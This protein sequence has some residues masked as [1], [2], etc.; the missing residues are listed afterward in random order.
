MHNIFCQN[1]QIFPLYKRRIDILC[2]EG[3]NTFWSIA[4]LNKSHTC[5]PD[6]LEIINFTVPLF[7]R[8]YAHEH[9]FSVSSIHETTLRN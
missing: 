9:T 6:V 7:F 4:D 1:S 5:I 2:S 3:I 8:K